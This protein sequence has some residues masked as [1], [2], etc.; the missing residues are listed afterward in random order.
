MAFDTIDK[1]TSLEKMNDLL[2][3]DKSKQPFSPFSSVQDRWP[4]RAWRSQGEIALGKACL[5]LTSYEI[6][7]MNLP[8]R[9][10]CPAGPGG[11]GLPSLPS[12]PENLSGTHILSLM[13]PRRD[14]L[15]V[16]SHVSF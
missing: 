11:P 12:R 3:R 2:K 7:K 1:D 9:P 16:S 13:P 10:V 15:R 5:Q 4:R 14:I 8:G 6:C